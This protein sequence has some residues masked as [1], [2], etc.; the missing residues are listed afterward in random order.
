M[1][2][3]LKN[4]QAL[5]TSVS[6]LQASVNTLQTSVNNVL[7]AVNGETLEPYQQF[8]STGCSSAGDCAIIFP[9]VTAKT[10]ILHASCTWS[11]PNRAGVLTD[12][13]TLGTPDF[14]ARQSIP[15]FANANTQGTVLYVFNA[16]TFLFVDSGHQPRIDVFSEGAAVGDLLCTISGKVP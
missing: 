8:S 2:D 15:F 3:V 13:A 14:T 6:A 11:L 10:L 4:L 9:A 16:E 1:P 7:T 12:F 5:Q